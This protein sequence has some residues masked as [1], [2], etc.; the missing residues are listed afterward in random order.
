MTAQRRR[1]VQRLHR[2]R[3]G[4]RRIRRQPGI[5]ERKICLRRTEGFRGQCNENIAENPRFLGRKRKSQQD[6]E[7]ND[8]EEEIGGRRQHDFI[9]QQR[10]RCGGAESHRGTQ[11]CGSQRQS[12]PD[13]EKGKKVA[14]PAFVFYR[15]GMEEPVRKESC[16]SARK[17]SGLSETGGRS[18]S[19]CR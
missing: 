5:P 8:C 15:S 19:D 11:T 3:G 4:N 10:P 2:K 13:D 7:E 16:F 12:S 14:L 9:C 17:R 6:Q 18:R 1:R